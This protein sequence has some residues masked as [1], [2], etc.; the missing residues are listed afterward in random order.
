MCMS[1]CREWEVLLKATW[2]INHQRHGWQ[3]AAFERYEHKDAKIRI[4]DVVLQTSPT[5]GLLILLVPFEAA[6][7]S[8]R[9]PIWFFKLRRNLPEVPWNPQVC[10]VK[11]HFLNPCSPLAWCT[12]AFC[13][14]VRRRMPERVVSWGPICVMA[15]ELGEI[16]WS[17][18]RGGPDVTNLMDNGWYGWYGVLTPQKKTTWGFPLV[19]PWLYMALPRLRFISLSIAISTSL[20]GIMIHMMTTFFCGKQNIDDRWREF[21]NSTFRAGVHKI[22]RLRG[23][24]ILA[25]FGNLMKFVA[26]V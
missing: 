5:R 21:D 2:H 12:T 25:V 14:K 17:E 10:A 11:L 26:V 16:R 1:L 7:W 19:K 8:D 4:Y 20:P 13:P 23:P 22:I 24:H 6:F 15:T 3:M 18:P 9:T